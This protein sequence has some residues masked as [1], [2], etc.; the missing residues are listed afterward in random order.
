M[1]E[2]NTAVAKTPFFA[3]SL[4]KLAVMTFCTAGLYELYWFYKN[5]QA[6]RDREFS[7]I[8]PTLRTAFALFFCYRLFAKVRN[9]GLTV[10][11]PSSLAAGWLATGW[12]VTG[13]IG[14]LPDPWSLISM[15][16]FLFL[17]P[18]QRVINQINQI[19]APGHAPNDTFSRWNWVWIGIGLVLT[20]AAIN[21]AIPNR[22]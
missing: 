11:A 20:I 10:N 22:P 4:F 2:V 15:C 8:N 13:L 9:L 12:I 17:L 1:S 6:V 3:V 19:C 5:W 14:L 7:T 16:T 21:M 18:V